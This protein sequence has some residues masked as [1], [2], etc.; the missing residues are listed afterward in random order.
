M[1]KELVTHIDASLH[2]KAVKPH[3][4]QSLA[5]VNTWEKYRV[6]DSE[7]NTYQALRKLDYSRYCVMG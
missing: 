4:V 6:S 1:S 3:C 7:N 5:S 2:S